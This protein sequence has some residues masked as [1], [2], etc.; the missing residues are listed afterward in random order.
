MCWEGGDYVSTSNH[1]ILRS[2]APFGRTETNSS[3][4]TE[5]HGI[6]N[7]FVIGCAILMIERVLATAVTRDPAIDIAR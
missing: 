5:L 3:A 7:K 4:G 1:S 2:L 6:I